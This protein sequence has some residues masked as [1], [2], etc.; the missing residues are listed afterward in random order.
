MLNYAC[1]PL[2]LHVATLLVSTLAQASNVSLDSVTNQHTTKFIFWF[3]NLVDNTLT[4][5]PTTLHLSSLLVEHLNCLVHLPTYL[6]HIFSRCE[7]SSS[8]LSQLYR[9]K[10]LPVTTLMT[11]FHQ[12]SKNSI[13]NS[14]MSFVWSC[15]NFVF[16]I[17]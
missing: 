15:S 7:H 3:T 1:I 9:W 14:T 4:G 8:T 13:F 17:S 12:P 10:Y 16:F 11:P 6:M 2:H 5:L